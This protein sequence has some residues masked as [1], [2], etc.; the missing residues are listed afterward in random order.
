MPTNCKEFT[1]RDAEAMERLGRQFAQYIKVSSKVYLTGDL[2]AGKTTF[3]RG[4]LGALGHSGVVKSPTFSFL[5]TYELDKMT[6]MHIDLYRLK[7]PEEM[8][9]YGLLDCFNDKAVVLLEWPERAQGAIPPPDFT[10]RI[11]FNSKG[12]KTEGRKLTLEMHQP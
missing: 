5:E 1:V 12:E 7:T 2:G 6:V 10:V 11:E 9:G 8:A 3:C 4:V